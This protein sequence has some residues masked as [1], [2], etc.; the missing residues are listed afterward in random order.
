M[1]PYSILKK[2]QYPPL[3]AV[4]L[5]SRNKPRA[6]SIFGQHRY[7]F[8]FNTLLNS[9]H[10]GHRSITYV[11]FYSSRQEIDTKRLRHWHGQPT[12]EVD[13]VLKAENKY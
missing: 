7:P 13:L 6:P 3:S 8:K 4:N 10:C 5:K 11:S 1:T 12:D 9:F 2:A